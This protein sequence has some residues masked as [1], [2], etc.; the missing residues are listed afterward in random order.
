MSLMQDHDTNKTTILD[1]L[2]DAEMLLVGIGEEFDEKKFLLEQER[3]LQIEEELDQNK[4]LWMLP[5]IQSY[6]LKD[7]RKLQ[8][9]YRK[10]EK[11]V[12]GKNYFILTTCM[13]GQLEKQALKPEKIVSPCGSYHKLQCE[14]ENCDT[15][16]DTPESLL[17]QIE[18]YISGARKPEQIEI[19]KCPKCGCPLVFNSLYTEHYK[20]QG[21]LDAWGNYT[22]WLQGT[23]NRKICLLELGVKMTFPSVIRFPFEKVAFFNKK[24]KLIRINETLYQL[25]E[26][27]GEKGISIAENAVEFM[28]NL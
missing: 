23:L 18:E 25:S 8:A 28:H 26:Q 27:I 3:Y 13:H 4:M 5:Y 12:E 9:A 17:R 6:F 14:A 21:Y 7:D 20:E 2:Q 16:C 24:A 15:L 10:L 22:K 19:P 1:E 11:C